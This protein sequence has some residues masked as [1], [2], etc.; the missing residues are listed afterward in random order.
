MQFA[1][2]IRRYIVT[3]RGPQRWWLHKVGRTADPMCGLCEEGVAQNAVHLLGCPGVADGKGRRWEEIWEDPEWCERLAEVP[4]GNNDTPG[5][6]VFETSERL[7][8]A[9][10]PP[11]QQ[12]EMQSPLRGDRIPARH[13]IPLKRKSIWGDFAAQ[14]K[15]VMTTI[16]HCHFRMLRKAKVK[17]LSEIV[18]G[19]IAAMFVTVQRMIEKAQGMIEEQYLL[20]H[21]SEVIAK[22]EALIRLNSHIE[23]EMQS[24]KKK[25]GKEELEEEELE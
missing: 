9:M 1:E 14:C 11:G 3:D 23:S 2:T 6:A 15:W 22:Y 4:V 24:L 16:Q 20:R 12:S 8:W 10:T 17:L 5:A 25:L 19:G 18:G 7:G 21:R 13:L